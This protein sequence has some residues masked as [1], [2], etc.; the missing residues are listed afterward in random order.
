MRRVYKR[1]LSALLALLLAMP[2]LSCGGG[3]NEEAAHA[4]RAPDG[5]ARCPVCGMKVLGWPGPKGQLFM[6]GSDQPLFFD[7]TVDLMRYLLH[8]DHKSRARQAYVQDMSQADWDQPDVAP[9]IDARKAWF[10]AGHSRMGSM[11]PTLASFADRDAAEHFVAQYQG[12]LLGYAAIDT[13]L[14]DA[15]TGA[16]S[17]DHDHSGH[18]GHAH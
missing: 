11:G 13:A 17:G 2:M 10:V 18:H 1:Y 6:Q 5:E 15:L 14:L 7:N 16:E 12:E 9:W 4:A 3:A 8:P